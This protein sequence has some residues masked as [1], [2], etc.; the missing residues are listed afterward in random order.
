MNLYDDEEPTF[1]GPGYE[2][3]SYLRW[4]RRSYYRGMRWH[5]TLGCLT[6]WAR[7]LLDQARWLIVRR[8]RIG[9]FFAV[10]DAEATIHC[11]EPFE[12]LDLDKHL[13]EWGRS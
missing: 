13:P 8:H 4:M 9:F 2:V 10:A 7:R 11:H 6:G 12:P 3:R 1:P 5:Y